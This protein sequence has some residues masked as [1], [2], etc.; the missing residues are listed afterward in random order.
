M[1]VC[2]GGR[3]EKMSVSIRLRNDARIGFSFSHS[4]EVMVGGAGVVVIGWSMYYHLF[5]S[6]LKKGIYTQMQT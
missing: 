6:S 1:G 5:F 2:F 4:F 3:G